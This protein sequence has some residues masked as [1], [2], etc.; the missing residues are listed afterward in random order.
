MSDEEV[1]AVFR[2]VHLDSPTPRATSAFVTPTSSTIQDRTTVER[3]SITVPAV[4]PHN[5][6]ENTDQEDHFLTIDKQ[7]FESDTTS[8]YWTG[9]I[10]K[11]RQNRLRKIPLSRRR[12]NDQF[13]FRTRKE[14]DQDNTT[15][16]QTNRK[17]IVPRTRRTSVQIQNPQGFNIYNPAKDTIRIIATEDQ[18]TRA[19]TTKAKKVVIGLQRNYW[20]D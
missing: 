14:P 2:R 17:T 16:N 1:E 12:L 11:E 4:T 13:R 6:I 3:T 20:R 5:S 15:R 7:Q 8:K 19:F 10:P 9:E 18:S